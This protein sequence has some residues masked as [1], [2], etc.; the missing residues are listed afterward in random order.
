[1]YLVHGWGGRGV[2]WRSFVRPLVDAGFTAVT[3]D[4]P[5]HGTA[6]GRH[7]SIV[8]FAATLSAVVESLGP[9]HAIVG[10]S[11]GGGACAFATRR[12]LEANAIVLIG[13]PADP[14]EYF[15]AFLTKL[16]MREELRA[17]TKDAFARNYGF[18]WSE[19]AIAPPARDPKPRALVVHD[20]DDANV[21]Y[22][23]AERIARSWPSSR[24]ETT[25][26]L[27]HQRILRSD[28]VI[29]TVVSFLSQLAPAS[30]P[31]S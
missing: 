1:V 27:G 22:R 2:Q 8:H 21:A 3:F 25:S 12:G 10:H 7:T 6:D 31:T 14:A 4:A 26:G 28:A 19:F 20:R 5:R 30:T 15:D 17:P 23:H 13:A 16:G 18:E 9:A 24:L 29:G 11:L